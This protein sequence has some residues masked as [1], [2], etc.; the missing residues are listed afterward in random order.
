[1][2][3]LYNQYNIPVVEDAAESLGSYYKEKHTGTFGHVSTFSF[4]GNKTVTS[5]GGAIVT[6][7]EALA[8]RAKHIATTAKIPHTMGICS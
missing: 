3:G 5:G 4:N 8:K 6:N 1:M 2:G 7:N